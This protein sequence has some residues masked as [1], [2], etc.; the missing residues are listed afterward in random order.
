MASCG[1]QASAAGHADAGAR[2]FVEHASRS[3]L[4]KQ[5]SRTNNWRLT[6]GG[7]GAASAC[8]SRCARWLTRARAAAMSR[9]K[10]RGRHACQARR[11]A[12]RTTPARLADLAL[13][14]AA[15]NAPNTFL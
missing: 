4:P 12:G 6:M 13:W 3:A 15:A 10:T 1:G 8:L 5:A 9:S 11:R 2:Q 7:D 14:P